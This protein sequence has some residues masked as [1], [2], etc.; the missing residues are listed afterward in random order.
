VP[1]NLDILLI[2]LMDALTRLIQM[3]RPQAG[4]DLRC[5]LSGVYEIPHDAA[6]EGFAPFHLVLSGSCRIEANGAWWQ[7]R[8]GDFILFPRG[9]AHRIRDDG[10]PGE[11]GPVRMRD[12]DMLPERRVGRGRIDA[13]LLC[14]HFTHVSGAGDLL[15]KALPDPLHVSLT[16]DATASLQVIVDLMR[17]EAAARRPGARAIVTALSQTLFAMA[18]RYYGERAEGDAGILALL[19]DARLGAS[20]QAV[21]DDPGQPWAIDTLG[22]RAAMSRATYARRFRDVSGMTVFEFVTRVRMAMACDLL[23]HTRRSAGEIA[24]TVGYQ[25]EAAF[26][27]AFRQHVGALPGQYRRRQASDDAGQDR[28]GSAAAGD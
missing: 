11:P 6:P 25:S 3:A 19:A 2:R 26:G 9:G 17:S 23:R 15:F 28:A 1:I 4:L 20:A 8:A 16:D 27:R 14:G 18:L 21:L 13:D 7:A 22:Q 24:V 5:R 10:A 12:D